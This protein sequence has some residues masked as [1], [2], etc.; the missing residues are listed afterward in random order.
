MT[1]PTTNPSPVA[2]TSPAPSPTAP[3]SGPVLS[4]PS[5]AGVPAVQRA[6]ANPTLGPWATEGNFALAQRSAA[7]LASSD[8]VP[9][10]YAGK[11][12]NCLIA[13]DIAHHLGI[14]PLMVMQNLHIIH[15]RPSWGSSFVIGALNSCGRFSPIRFTI[16]RRGKKK[17]EVTTWTGPKGNRTPSREAREVDDVECV[18]Y[19][20]ELATGE[21][22]EGPAVTIEMAIQEGW[23]AKAESKWLTMPDLMLRYRAAAFFGRLYAPDILMGMH[24]VEEV[25]DIDDDRPSKTRG[26]G[27]ASSL[28][29]ALEEVVT[30]SSNAHEAPAAP[31]AES[32]STNGAEPAATADPAPKDPPSIATPHDP[33]PVPSKFTAKAIEKEA[34]G[35]T[36]SEKEAES[37]RDYRLDLEDWQ[38]RHPT[39]TPTT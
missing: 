38:K 15:G 16:A 26:R 31:A 35:G 29:E 20:T 22:I 4:P 19:A 17:I 13:I 9:T 10:S 1:G 6:P 7:A 25:I 37:I 11:A 33:A 14:S 34:A 18:A 12:A 28:Q 3:A 36:L 8:L 21:R 32:A 30:V 23:T 2:T 39:G 5:V 24:T 27:G